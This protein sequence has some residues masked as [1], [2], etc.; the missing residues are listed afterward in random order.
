[1]DLGEHALPLLEAGG[2]GTLD[3]R[4]GLEQSC[5]VYFYE[6]GAPRRHRR[7][8]RDGAPLRARRAARASTCRASGRARADR[9][10]KQAT[11]GE[12]WQLGETLIVRHRPGLRAGDAAAARGHDG[13]LANG[14]ARVSRAWLRAVARPPRR[15]RGRADCRRSASRTR[16]LRLVRDGMWAVVN[17][18]RGT[19]AR[20]AHSP[21]P[22][23][24]MAGKTGTSQVRR[25]SRAERAT[26]RPQ[27]RGH[28]LG[29]ARPRAVR[30]LCAATRAALRRRRGGRARRQRQRRR[31][32]PS[33]ATSWPRRSSCDPARA[34][35]RVAR[36]AARRAGDAG[37]MA[38]AAAAARAASSCR[39][40][41]S[42][43]A[44]ALAVRAAARADRGWSASS[45][46]TPPAGGAPSPGRAPG[47]ALRR[48]PRADAVARADRHPAVV[49][50]RLCRSMPASL[51]A[52][53]RG[54]VR[55]RASAWA[56]SA[57]STSA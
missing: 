6:I 48:R 11:Q 10:W 51:L 3:M 27:E 19:A 33:R 1:M 34:G 43:A 22:A 57:G 53:R 7:D 26:R 44:S 5:D 31:A 12:P 56:R 17:G 50:A 25:I 35:R 18:A 42:S 45:C 32:A 9:A 41:T 15:G 30:R 21:R 23:S 29:G 24:Q 14:G 49:C 16:H 37:L 2:H 4:D 40:S 39:C 13:A 55:R 54:R 38:F 36:T 8:R 46:C 28:A 20:R 52:A 47:A